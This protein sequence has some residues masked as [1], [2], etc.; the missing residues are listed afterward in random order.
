MS[1]DP[2]PVDGSCENCEE[3][4]DDPTGQGPFILEAV[5]GEVCSFFL[6]FAD[7]G[8]TC[9]DPTGV[10]GFYAEITEVGGSGQWDITLLDS[11]GATIVDWI[12]LTDF[13]ITEEGCKFPWGATPFEVNNHDDSICSW[14]DPPNPETAPNITPSGT[15]IE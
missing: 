1:F 3:F 4:Q 2:A 8:I 7:A 10:A 9:Y 11:A 14:K 6:S 12:F 15:C 5:S 13:N